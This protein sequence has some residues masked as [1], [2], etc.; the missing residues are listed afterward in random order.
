[1]SVKMVVV[2]SIAYDSLETPKGKRER[3][4]GGSASYFSTV[5]CYCRKIRGMERYM[6]YLSSVSSFDGGRIGP[7]PVYGDWLAAEQT[8]PEFLC[9]MWYGADADA[10]RQ[11]CGIL[12]K[13][14]EE[15]AYAELFEKIRKFLYT[16]YVSGKSL[17]QT[18]TLF[19]LH[20]HL[21][22]PENAGGLTEDALFEQLCSAVEEN[23]Y[24]LATGFAGTP[25][26]LPELC[27]GGR[28]DLAYK[29]L[30]C[31]ENPSWMYSIDQGATTIWE[32]YDSYT[33]EKGF[34]D[35]AMNSFDHFNEGSV[36]QW[37]YEQMAGICVDHTME[38][39][40]LISPY[41]PDASLSD[42]LQK[43]SGSYHSIYG[44]IT[45]DWQITGKGTG[46]TAAFDITVPVNTQAVLD[47][48][49]EGLERRSVPGGSYH[50][51]GTL[52]Q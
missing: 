35:A 17:T 52:L 45:V 24:K 29:V 40:I 31:R 11:V 44:T 32:R 15:K 50:F 14:E 18:E 43:V 13:S 36:A 37:M 8:D 5:A 34:A 20:Y 22:D 49:I 21:L 1:M 51:E 26:L 28:Q 41:L 2:G 33:K 16:R 47:L 38:D 4:L 25:L 23:D 30:L 7:A 27:R 42:T 19:L 46:R 12:K 9:A 10:M 48:P 3:V 39:P 6:D